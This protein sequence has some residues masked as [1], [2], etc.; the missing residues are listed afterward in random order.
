MRC[1]ITITDHNKTEWARMAAAASAAD[2]VDVCRR[3]TVAAAIPAGI[4]LPC[5]DYDA[6]QDA[7]RDWLV[8]SLWPV[9]GAKR[10]THRAYAF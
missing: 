1:G 6:L 4:M 7:Y 9:S 10:Y 2:Q 3:Y 5:A 8:F